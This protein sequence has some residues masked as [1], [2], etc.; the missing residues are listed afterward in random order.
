MEDVYA[1]LLARNARETYPFVAIH[2]SNNTLLNQVDALQDKCADLEREISK[3][4]QD[5]DD[6][7]GNGHG[8]SISGK[9]HSAAATAALK[10]EARLRDRVSGFRLLTVIY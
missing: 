9:G 1:Q 5:L 2:E 3:L 6:A 10:N 7:V 4:H 8:G